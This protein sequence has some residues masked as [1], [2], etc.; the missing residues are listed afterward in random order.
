MKN[1][2]FREMK[3]RLSLSAMKTRTPI[4]G[5]YELTSRCNLDCRMCYVH[6][7]CSNSLREKELSTDQWKRIF[8]EAFDLGLIY[9]TLTGGECLLRKDFKEL[10]LYLWHKG[11]YVSVLTNGVLLDEE[12]ISFFKQ[13]MPNYIQIS[14]YGS[15]EEGYKH[16]TGHYG[17]S[18]VVAAIQGLQREGI[19]VRVTITPSA[20]IRD[21]Y[22]NTVRFVK[23][24][25]FELVN[26]EMCLIPKRDDPNETEHYLSEDDIYQLSMEKALLRGELCSIDSV[27]EVEGTFET[28][29][30]V[31]LTCSGGNCVAFVSWEGIMHPCI[32]LLIGNASLTEMSYVEAWESTKN[33]AD[34]VVYGAECVGCAYDKTCPKCPTFRL[35]D[36]YSG[37]CKPEMCRLTQRLVSGGIKKIKTD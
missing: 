12:Y 26:T 4:S 17:F 13:Y 10:Y 15:S 5:V 22:I 20:Y 11:V 24:N 19:D 34:Q 9:A 3:K 28:A 29:P 27:P 25:N 36:Y 18:K 33:A 7:A 21:D 16:V 31:G 6:N 8:E 2:A 14:L 37:H 23:D 1:K 32:N 35:K 30:K